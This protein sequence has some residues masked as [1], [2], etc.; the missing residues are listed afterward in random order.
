MDTT[1]I[2]SEQVEPTTIQEAP[3]VATWDDVVKSFGKNVSI[4]GIWESDGQYSINIVI[5]KRGGRTYIN[6]C[7]ITDTSLDRDSESV[8]KVSGLTYTD[9]HDGDDMSERFIIEGSILQSY[10]Y[11]SDVNGGEWV[12]M[13]NYTKVY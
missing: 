12:F 8:L 5:Y 1:S 13:G 2:V 7:Q 11:N 10:A 3:K 6:T 4:I 9:Y